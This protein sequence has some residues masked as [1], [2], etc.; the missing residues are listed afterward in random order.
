M[1]PLLEAVEKCIKYYGES[2]LSDE[3][4]PD[5]FSRFGYNVYMEARSTY[6]FRQQKHVVSK[7]IKER[8]EKELEK[9][10]GIATSKTKLSF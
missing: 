5:A 2:I 3:T 6:E 7:K 9:L 10:G 8:Q 4:L 1:V